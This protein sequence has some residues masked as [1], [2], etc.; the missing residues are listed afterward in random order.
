[1]SITPPFESFYFSIEI[2][3]LASNH[4]SIGLSFFMFRTLCSLKMKFLITLKFNVYEK[5]KIKK[6]CTIIDHLII[7]ES[8]LE[9]FSL[10]CLYSLIVSCSSSNI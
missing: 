3:I 4:I 2:V 7:S 9:C 10:D 8:I 1:M 6:I 5:L